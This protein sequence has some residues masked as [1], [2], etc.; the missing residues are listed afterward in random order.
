MQTRFQGDWQGT[1]WR[2]L[3]NPAIEVVAAI[4][5]MLI[6]AWIVIDTEVVQ[7]GVLQVPVP[8]VHK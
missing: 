7:S 8:F 1:I 6:A 4:V 3:T 2:L 5:V